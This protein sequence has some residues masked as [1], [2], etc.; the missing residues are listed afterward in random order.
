MVGC[1]Q[2][3]STDASA[4]R[5]GASGSSS[6]AGTRDDGGSSGASSAGARNDAGAPGSSLAGARDDG[7]ASG[8]AGARDDGAVP[9]H[10]SCL[11]VLQC[12]GAC[13]DESVDACV[14]ACLDATSDSS[15]PVTAA[16]IQ[17]IADNQCVEAACIRAA[18]ESQ[19]SECVADDASAAAQGEPSS[20]TAPTGSVPSDLV[21]LWSQVGLTS[22][23]SFEFAAD[24][25]TTQAYSNETNYGCD[26]KTQLS[27]SGVT[28][29]SGDSLVYHR[30]Q[31]TLLTKSCG[32]IQSKTVEPADI[33]YRYSLGSFDDGEA[34]LSL[35][36]VNEDGSLSTPIEL[37]R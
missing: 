27:S 32:T 7:G 8:F 33:A 2:D 28:T 36:R 19:L 26:L 30:L 13:P 11:G 18:C 3:A 24:G 16:L 1:T 15:Q 6:F 4:D 12:A 20:G 23:M 22:G 34:K 17:C 25:E 29:V 37:H 9:S 10:L 35:S 5:G 31:G 21:G 14:E